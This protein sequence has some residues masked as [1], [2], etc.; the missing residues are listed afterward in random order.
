MKKKGIIFGIVG[1]LL[2]CVAVVFVLNWNRTDRIN[3]FR[4]ERIELMD[5]SL[6]AEKT[7]EFIRLFNSASYAG[8][9]IGDGGTP[10][11]QVFVYYRDGS[12]LIVSDFRAADRDF[13]VTLREEDGEKP[14]SYYV[15]SEE[16]KEFV[17]E[18]YENK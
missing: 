8:E 14:V 3:A 18:L 16:L 7:R 5:G 6:S 12:C 11:Y 17:S 15:N 9:W 13:E 10:D 2:L 4:V 1:V